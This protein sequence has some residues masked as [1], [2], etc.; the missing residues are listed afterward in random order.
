MSALPAS[1]LKIRA[2]IDAAERAQSQGNATEAG[3]LLALAQTESPDNPAVF[4]AYGV[5]ALRNGDA[6]TAKAFFEKAIAR[7]GATP[8]LYLN[9]A[10][11]LRDVGDSVGEMDALQSAL[12]LDPYF[13]LAQFQ[14]ASLLEK[15]GQAKLAA[16]TFHAALSSLRPGSQIPSAMQPVIEHAQRCVAANFQDLDHFLQERLR[17]IRERHSGAAQDRVDDC[18]ASLLG[19][20]RIY[21][22]QPTFTH[23]PRLPAIEF[24]AR[25]QFSWLP[26]VEAA[27]DDIRAEL[28]QIL[29]TS[30]EDF[31]P[32][33][34]HPPQAPLN[35]WKELNHSRRWSS[36]FL[37]KEGRRLDQNIAR[38]PK[39]VAAV[40][41]AP[42]VDIERRGP[43]CFFSRLEPRTRIPP[44]TGV[45]NARL[46]VHI[47]L[48]VPPECGFR[49]GSSV[50]E[51]VPGRALVFD[52]TIEHEAW[53]DSGEPRVILIFDIW[54]PLLTAAE[55]E[56]MAAATTAI[57]DFYGD[58]APAFNNH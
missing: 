47:P 41:G 46:T 43:T 55:R 17:A 3:Q 44:H 13:Y 19:R 23:F 48:I 4:A 10:S 40:A 29:H 32:Y 12:A 51:W 30:L 39:T 1:E 9:L 27:T 49:V 22:Q 11:A 57:A 24:F 28:S 58:F 20:K 52:D 33:V 5:Q 6:D 8:S 56:L 37:F 35:Q 50:R 7:N 31:S 45:T 2:L 42:V 15:L 14:K 26:A 16:G 38:C 21:V 34:T 36:L 18:L 53:N 25:E 54:N